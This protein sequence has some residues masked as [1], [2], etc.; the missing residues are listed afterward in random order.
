MSL[1]SHIPLCK[2]DVCHYLSLPTYIM[3]V[4]RLRCLL[5]S[6]FPGAHDV[7]NRRGIVMLYPSYLELYESGELARR[8]DAAW[9]ILRSCTICPQN[10]G[11]DRIAGKTGVCHSK[12]E[13]IVASWNVHRREEP[14]IS[15]TRGAGTIFLA[16]ARPAAPTARTFL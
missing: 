15:G 9:E 6:S 2:D 10:C 3:C 12:T 7:C 13:A 4:G 11:C 5:L 1:A 14:P 16:T 8:A